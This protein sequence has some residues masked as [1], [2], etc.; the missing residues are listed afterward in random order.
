MLPYQAVF[1]DPISL[2]VF[3]NVGD[4]DEDDT[5]AHHDEAHPHNCRLVL[6]LNKRLTFVRSGSARANGEVRLH[7]TRLTG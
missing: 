6:I 7:P 1:Q 5:D 4:D 3:G 2:V